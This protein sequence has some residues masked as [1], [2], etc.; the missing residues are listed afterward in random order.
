MFS[1]FLAEIAAL[2]TAPR[3]GA[4]ALVNTREHSRPLC[5]TTGG[6]GG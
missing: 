1:T 6:L 5:T 3:Q 4:M 2:A